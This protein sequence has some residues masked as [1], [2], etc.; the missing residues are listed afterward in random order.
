[1]ERPVE[2]N[3]D[4]TLHPANVDYA[5]L[6]EDMDSARD[7]LGF[8]SNGMTNNEKIDEYNYYDNILDETAT[9]DE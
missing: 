7:Y 2:N 8:I 5:V 3:A 1:M 9:D 4:T 6:P